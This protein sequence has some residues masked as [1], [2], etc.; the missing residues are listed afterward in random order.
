M[1]AKQGASIPAEG[2]DRGNI[3]YRNLRYNIEL[4]PIFTVCSVLHALIVTATIFADIFAEIIYRTEAQETKQALAPQ[5][6]RGRQDAVSLPA[7]H[8]QP[9]ISAGRSQAMTRPQGGRARR[10]VPP[11]PAGTDVRPSSTSGGRSTALVTSGCPLSLSFCRAR[12]GSTGVI[13]GAWACRDI[14]PQEHRALRG[15]GRSH[16]SL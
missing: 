16:S 6:E 11:A 14:N 13:L 7:T 9:L 3:F 5:T 10:D 12:V 4:G 15:G 2:A 8:T 1:S